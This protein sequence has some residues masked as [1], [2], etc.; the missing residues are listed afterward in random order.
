[1]E[2]LDAVTQSEWIPPPPVDAAADP[3]AAA[4]AAEEAAAAA[5]AAAEATPLTIDQSHEHYKREYVKYLQIYTKLVNAHDNML[6]P[7]KRLDVEQLVKITMLRLVE[8]RH[9]MVHWTPADEAIGGVLEAGAPAPWEYVAL[10]DVLRDYH[11]PL[12]HGALDVPVPRFFKL[13]KH[14][15]E[16]KRKIEGYFQL[17]VGDDAGAMHGVLEKPY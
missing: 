5:A 15:I 12:S 14:N 10:D 13:D 9:L 17:V 6:H 7:Q 3:E 11:P 1:M 8:L 4:A 2:E 16:C